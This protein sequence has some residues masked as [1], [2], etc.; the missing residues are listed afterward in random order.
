M[1]DGRYRIGNSTGGIEREIDSADL[2]GRSQEIV[3][4]LTLRHVWK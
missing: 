1:G 4:Q 2:A 3:S